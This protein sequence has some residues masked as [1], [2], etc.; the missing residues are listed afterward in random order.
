MS[1]AAPVGSPWLGFCPTVVAKALLS[2][3]GPEWAKCCAGVGIVRSHAALQCP[4]RM[5]GQGT[6]WTLFA[7]MVI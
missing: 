3:S 1:S 6:I 7:I 5:K 2:Q 4:T